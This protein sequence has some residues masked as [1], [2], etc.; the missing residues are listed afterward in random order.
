MEGKTSLIFKCIPLSELPEIPPTH[1]QMSHQTISLNHSLCE[2]QR[3]VGKYCLQEDGGFI[4]SDEL[5][6][7]E[8]LSALNSDS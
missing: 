8:L 4:H 6:H 1:W 5:V 3:L 7:L 2:L